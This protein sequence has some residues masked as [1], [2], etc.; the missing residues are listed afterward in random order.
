[1][2][3]AS[4]TYPNDAQH[5]I[6]PHHSRW[7]DQSIKASKLATSLRGKILFM[8]TSTINLESGPSDMTSWYEYQQLESGSSIRLLKI[9]PGNPGDD[10]NC[11]IFHALLDRDG[12]TP[13]YT[14][15][16]YVWGPLQPQKAIRCNGFR[17][18]ITLNLQGAIRALRKVEETRVMWIDYICLYLD[19]HRTKPLGNLRF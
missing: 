16:S 13:G 9:L 14:A 4:F 19:R 15:L 10:I 17:F 12:S 7:Y 11:E 1:M 5:Y 18:A 2:I 6:F 3:H 8:G